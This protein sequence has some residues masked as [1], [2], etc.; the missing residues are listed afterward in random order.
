MTPLD[1]QKIDRGTIFGVLLAVAGVIA[2]LLLDGGTLRQ[3]LQ[4]TAALIVLG[5]T[6][7]AVMVQF[8]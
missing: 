4:P 5:G 8:P 1:R 2:G 7:G 6:F 3:I